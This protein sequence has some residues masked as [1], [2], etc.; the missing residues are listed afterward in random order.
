MPPLPG[1]SFHM[2]VECL[3]SRFTLGESESMA[4]AFVSVVV[5]AILHVEL[6]STAHSIAHLWGTP[7]RREVSVYNYLFLSHTRKQA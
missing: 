3:F 2:L 6:L 7:G 4:D 1:L 5:I